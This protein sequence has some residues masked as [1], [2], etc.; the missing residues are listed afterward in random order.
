MLSAMAGRS[1]EARKVLAELTQYAKP[2]D[3][4]PAADCAYIH[5]LL[6]EKEQ[7]FEGLEKAY[8]GRAS[9][10]FYIKL[11]P[12]LDTLRTDPRFNSLLSRMG[13]PQ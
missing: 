1:A 10:L 12:S 2:P 11:R 7:A 5:A 13:L 3:F 9:T 6:G 4:L 8:Q